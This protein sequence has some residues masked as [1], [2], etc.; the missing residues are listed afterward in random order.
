MWTFAIV[1]IS[2]IAVAGF[3]KW[4]RTNQDPLT[5]M[6]SNN[7][8]MWVEN[9]KSELGMDNYFS[10]DD[11][12]DSFEMFTNPVYSYMPCNIHYEEW[13]K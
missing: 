2:I 5:L 12:E 13:K 3:F 1:V 10:D 4:H 7:R 11:K 9:H 6:A 8:K